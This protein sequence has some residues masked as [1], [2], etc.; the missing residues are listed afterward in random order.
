MYV[1]EEKQKQT[2]LRE[3]LPAASANI[4]SFEVYQSI[5][6]ANTANCVFAVRRWL[7]CVYNCLVY[8]I[9]YYLVLEFRI[10]LR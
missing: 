6:A 1:Q 7:K 8:L 5:H 10:R 9:Y 4:R 3:D 2:G